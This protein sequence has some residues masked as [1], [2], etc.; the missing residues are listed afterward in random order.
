[1]LEEQKVL[2]KGPERIMLIEIFDDDAGVLE[3]K[4]CRFLLE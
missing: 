4:I 1:M 3:I 2:V